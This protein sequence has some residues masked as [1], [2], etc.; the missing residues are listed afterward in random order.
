MKYIGAI[1][2]LALAA[3][4]GPA[5]A[6]TQPGDRQYTVLTDHLPV[7]FDRALRTGADLIDRGQV[8]QFEVLLTGRGLILA[9]PGSTNAQR[10]V[11]DLLR[12]HRGLRIVACKETVDALT[13]AARRRPQLLPGTAVEPCI[14]RLRKM[15]AA[16]WQRVPG[17]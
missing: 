9:I 14:G 7:A 16:G 6:Q 4:A 8:R 12:R 10:G 5:A 1:A 17:L 11:A 15:D 13:S 3:A 2:A